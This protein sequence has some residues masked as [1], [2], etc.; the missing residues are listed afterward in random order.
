MFRRTLDSA[1]PTGRTVFHSWRRRAPAIHRVMAAQRPAQERQQAG[2]G[3]LRR[4]APIEQ[5]AARRARPARQPAGLEMDGEVLAAPQR[6]LQYPGRCHAALGHGLDHMRLI[7]PD[8]ARALARQAHQHIAILAA[9]QAIGRIEGL[10]M[11]LEPIGPDKE[12]AQAQ[13]IERHGLARAKARP[14]I[15]APPAHPGR[16][17]GRD[18]VQHGRLH[19]IGAEPGGGLGQQRQPLRRRAFIVI[20]HRQPRAAGQLDRPIA[21]QRN[22]LL[23]L[24]GVVHPHAQRLQRRLARLDH[25]P[26][27]AFGIVVHHDH[28]GGRER[29][30]RQ[31]AQQGIQQRRAPIGGNADADRADAHGLLSS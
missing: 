27:A 9:G 5:Q 21:G 23:G 14:I 30:R 13:G 18:L 20:D 11:T 1:H 31:I 12:I 29:L 19:G 3:H 26:G 7:A 17:R 22:I 6:A 25:G 28:L 2:G 15:E 8:D 10:R 4:G 24:D 16:R